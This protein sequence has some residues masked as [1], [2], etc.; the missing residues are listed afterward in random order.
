MY[1]RDVCNP[2]VK[3]TIFET[4]A[5]SSAFILYSS[6]IHID[7]SVLN[8]ILVREFVFF[9]FPILFGRQRILIYIV[10][11]IQ[12]QF[13]LSSVKPGFSNLSRAFGY[14]GVKQ[15]N[16]FTSLQIVDFFT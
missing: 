10:Y 15:L 12:S 11:A 5:M 13:I 16:Y 3:I 8:T 7:V 14:L 1:I 6:A 4:F 2:Y 9:I